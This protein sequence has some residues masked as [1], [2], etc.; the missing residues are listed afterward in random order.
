MGAIN[1]RK[2]NI[3]TTLDVNMYEVLKARGVKVSAALEIGA[4]S[5]INN[6]APE[7]PE[8]LELQRKLQKMSMLLDEKI[9]IIERLECAD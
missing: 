7:N 2:V 5:I 4:R 9:Q 3:C 1:R 6:T 8:V